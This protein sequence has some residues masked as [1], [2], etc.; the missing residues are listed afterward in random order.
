MYKLNQIENKL[1]ELEGGR[2]Q[3]LCNELL[4]RQGYGMV[5]KS[6]G[7][8]G[9]D[10][11]IKG[12]P[13]AYIF[14]SNGKFK[15]IEYTV[16]E[17]KVF[18]KFKDDIS[19]CL[20]ERKTSVPITKIE[21]VIIMYNSVLSV[22]EVN[23]LSSMCTENNV[24]FEKFDLSNISLIIHTKFP[25]LAKDFLGLNIDSGQFLDYKSFIDRSEK[26]MLATPL[27]IAI[28]GRDKEVEEVFMNLNDS[29][30]VLLVGKSG[31]GKTRVALEVLKRYEETYKNY[32]IWYV[33]DF[34]VSLYDDLMKYTATDNH[35]VFIDDINKLTAID[36]I[37]SYLT[38]NKKRIKLL[39]TVRDY[40]LSSSLNTIVNYIEPKVVEIEKLSDD[41]IKEIAEKNFEINNRIYLDRISSLAQGNSRLAVM[42][43]IITVKKDSLKSIDNI[44][45]LLERYYDFAQIKLESLEDIDKLKALAILSFLD[46]IHL[47]DEKSVIDICRLIRIDAADLKRHYK[48]LLTM[49]LVDIFEG[50]VVSMS[51]QIL[52]V[53][54]FHYVFEV[55][56]IIS[57][58]DIIK[59]YFPKYTNRIAQNMNSITTYYDN[60]EFFSDAVQIVW[61]EWKE[62]NNPNFTK[63]I[64]TFWFVKESETLLHIS[65]CIDEMENVDN[66]ITEYTLGNFENLKTNE[67]LTALGQFANSK[68]YEMA[69][70][71]L[72]KY[73]EK[74]ASSIKEVSNIFIKYYGYNKNS[75][76]QGYEYQYKV[77]A[78]IYNRLI[79]KR[80]PELFQLFCNV[81]SAFLV[82]DFDYIE[83]QNK[84]AYLY[85]TDTVYKYGEMTK[86]RE[87]IWRFVVYCIEKDDSREYVDYLLNN[88][89]AGRYSEEIGD[90]YEYDFN[91]LNDNVIPCLKFDSIKDSLLIDLVEQ[92]VFRYLNMNFEVN[93]KNKSKS[94]QTYKLLS[95][96]PYDFDDDW[97][98]GESKRKSELIGFSQKLNYSN[99]NDFFAQCIEIEKYVKDKAEIMDSIN[100]ILCNVTNKIEALKVY[101]ITNTPFTINP[102]SFLA[103]VIE[104]NQYQNVKN[105]IYNN[106][107]KDDEYW[108]FLLF[109]LI[110][111]REICLDDC[112][113]MLYYFKEQKRT[114]VEW[115][116]SLDYLKKYI[117]LD[118]NIY[119][120]VCSIILSKKDDYLNRIYFRGIFNYEEKIKEIIELFN[121][122]S[123]LENVYLTL[124]KNGDVYDPKG[125]IITELCRVDGDLIYEA[126]D[127][128]FKKQ[129]NNSRRGDLDFSFIWKFSKERIID[130]VDYVMK[131]H[132][133]LNI[134]SNIEKLFKVR[135]LYNVCDKQNEVVYDYI[136][137]YNCDE[138]KMKTLFYCIATF[139]PERQLK[140]IVTFL[141]KNPSIESFK[142]IP[143]SKR[144]ESISGSEIPLIM[145]KITFYEELNNRLQGIEFLEHKAYLDEIINRNN[146]S[147]KKVK[148]NEFLRDY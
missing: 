143:L 45:E 40:A 96:N 44:S 141:N 128:L 121:D 8:V 22:G 148:I 72:I 13:D 9:T 18:E 62:D 105:I 31:V 7:Q 126:C 38:D 27:N 37:M 127:V 80:T 70:E 139:D 137:E 144:V 138:D 116:R 46:K 124:L 77:I 115:S 94:F 67:L 10:K 119:Q 99:I 74:D 111:G 69:I 47:G 56:K 36:A 49:E 61:D 82:F 84:K 97:E 68:N 136:S 132:S 102:K 55:K 147:I 91:Q 52:S 109:S 1:K 81:A 92:N 108:K 51:D 64:L 107:F 133:E 19:K 14:N 63:L 145:R 142:L 57:Y 42:M 146:S 129:I 28:M 131:N 20:D 21:R 11:T 5:T 140:H 100:F 50:E 39:S 89:N 122:F 30:V 32:N 117:K 118:L 123:I 134:S 16:K 4:D 88:Y 43:S 66:I 2:F 83:K 15:F 33:K 120:K 60:L 103:G 12:T 26:G 113:K 23:Q 59:C 93:I 130:I 17:K 110:P 78:F 29:A 35:I 87:Y 86:L 24:K 90:L 85:T 53:F 76:S 3:I 75:Y 73:L 135:D 125:I 58:S 104:E 98:M 54:I 48:E 25:Y 41:A 101:L 34:G 95:S 106:S 112:T 6:G 79:K 114:S 65:N 71:L